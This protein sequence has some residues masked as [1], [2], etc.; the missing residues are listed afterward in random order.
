MDDRTDV[1]AANEA[2]YRAFEK[3]DLEAMEAVCSQGVATLC[4]HPGRKALK[5]WKDIR[6]SWELIFRNTR[7]LEID[8]DVLS[9]E[10]RESLAYVV[11]V[12]KVLQMN[13]RQRLEAKS[14]ATN[15]FEKMGGQWYLVSHHG[16]PI[17]G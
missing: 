15:I 6:P 2:F 17:L 16:S 13:G 11:V 14:V 1:L 12:E 8:L 7:Y 9:V 5:G 10:V 4:I 3:K